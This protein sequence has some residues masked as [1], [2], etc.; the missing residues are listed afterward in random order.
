MSESAAKL[1][2]ATA[3]L[4]AM[5]DTERLTLARTL[6]DG[7]VEEDQQGRRRTGYLA[8][9]SCEELAARL[10]M[11]ELLR[12]NSPLDRELRTHLADLFNP[13]S[14]QERKIEIVF[15]RQGGRRDHIANTQIA[16]HVYDQVAAG[17]NVAVGIN[18][19]VE[20]FGVSEELVKK[21]WGRYRRQ[22]EQV[23]GPL[24]GRSRGRSNR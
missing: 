12:S 24:P 20:K 1:Q 2:S 23:D 21:I 5:P 11:A 17:G 10:V 4:A 19:A 8:K 6:L 18:S 9:G 22:L 13:G 16:C 14:S 7:F 3:L 15:R